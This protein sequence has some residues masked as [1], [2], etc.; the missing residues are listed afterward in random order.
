M[1]FKYEVITECSGRDC[2]GPITHG[3][4]RQTMTYAELSQCIGGAFLSHG[5]GHV[6]D[7]E[8]GST[9][10]H[11]VFGHQHDEG[12]SRMDVSFRELDQD[13]LDTVQS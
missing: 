11:M 7:I 2:D 10:T 3:E 4:R 1:E 6:Q 9:W 13:E 8:D 5:N 12:F